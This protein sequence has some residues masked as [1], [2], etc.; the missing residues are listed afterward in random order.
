MVSPGIRVKVARFP[1]NTYF[2]H[3]RHI[4]FSKPELTSY[5]AS[6]FPGATDLLY[7]ITELKTKE[8][9]E[10]KKHLTVIATTIEGVALSLKMAW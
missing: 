2:Y 1:F 10:L 8:W 4:I 9:G 7:E 6:A 5:G 3:S